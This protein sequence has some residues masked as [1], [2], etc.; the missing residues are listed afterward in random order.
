MLSVHFGPFEAVSF[1]VYLGLG[2]SLAKRLSL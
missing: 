1:L 2:Q